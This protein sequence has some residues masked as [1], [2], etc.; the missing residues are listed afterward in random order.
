[1]PWNVFPNPTEYILCASLVTSPQ[2][3][4]HCKMDYWTKLLFILFKANHTKSSESLSQR[5]RADREDKRKPFCEVPERRPA[6]D[7]PLAAR[8]SL[9]F[10]TSC[11]TC[12][13]SSQ[14]RP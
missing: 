10:R 13:C 4:Q 14:Q 12:K 1:M 5:G 6:A 3:I 2:S 11:F 7:I 8:L 9:S